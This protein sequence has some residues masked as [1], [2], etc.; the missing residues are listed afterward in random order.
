MT[1]SAAPDQLKP[2]DPDLHCKDRAYSGSAGPELK[3][4]KGFFIEITCHKTRIG[5]ISKGNNSSL[6]LCYSQMSSISDHILSLFTTV[7][8]IT[9]IH[10]FLLRSKADN[11]PNIMFIEWP[12]FWNVL[13]NLTLVSDIWNFG[14]TSMCP[15]FFFPG[16]WKG[17]FYGGFQN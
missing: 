9:H 6:L 7:C 8:L 15:K 11:M 17:V 3:K 13:E 1:N 16:Y 4:L 12:V 10:I 2:T 14:T 5:M